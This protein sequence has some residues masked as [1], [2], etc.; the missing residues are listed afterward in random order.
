M[1]GLDG[2]GKTSLLSRFKR[3]GTERVLPETVTTVGYNVDTVLYGRHSIKIGEFG[4]S[5]KIRPLWR[6]FLLHCARPSVYR[7]YPALV[8]VVDAAAPTRFLEAKEAL[9]RIEMDRGMEYHPVLV[10]ANKVDS[11]GAVDLA[12]IDEVLGIQRLAQAGRTI[13]LK[14]I[15]AL[16]ADGIDEALEWLVENVSYELIAEIDM[17]KKQRR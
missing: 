6:S 8:F 5:D 1:L 12:V 7:N 9:A 14:G 16:T 11:A 17:L 10:L 4:G 15:S 13:S 3:R 2:A